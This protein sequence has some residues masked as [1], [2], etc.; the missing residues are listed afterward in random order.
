[1]L[2]PLCYGSFEIALLQ[3]VPYFD[4][5][6]YRARVEKRSQ[7]FSLCIFPYMA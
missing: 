5:L 3:L 4:K 1:M 6:T 2:E 7:Y